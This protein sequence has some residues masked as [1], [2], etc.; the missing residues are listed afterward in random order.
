MVRNYV[1]IKDSIAKLRTFTRPLYGITD[2]DVLVNVGTCHREREKNG[3]TGISFGGN[4]HCDRRVEKR[5]D[6]RFGRLCQHHGQARLKSQHS[7]I[8][9]VDRDLNVIHGNLYFYAGYNIHYG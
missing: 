4:F 2:N 6:L 1:H 5:L 3:W 9:H 7:T 8:N